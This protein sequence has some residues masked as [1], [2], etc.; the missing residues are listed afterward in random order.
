MRIKMSD[1]KKEFFA[2]TLKSTGYSHFQCGFDKDDLNP[3]KYQ[4]E[5]MFSQWHPSLSLTV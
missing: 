4:F 1:I 5:G 3:K 2:P